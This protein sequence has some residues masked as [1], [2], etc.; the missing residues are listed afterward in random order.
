MLVLEYLKSLNGSTEEILEQFKESHSIKYKYYPEE[1]LVVLNYNQ[2]ESIKDDP[3]VM[4]CRSLVLGISDDGFY[5]VSRAFHRFFN[6]GECPH[7]EEDFDLE[8]AICFEKL[9]GSV[10]RI[11]WYKD[12]WEIGTKGTAFGETENYTGVTFRELVLNAF[13]F[14]DTETLEEKEEH[15]QWTFNMLGSKR[16]TYVME[17]CGKDNRVV[18]PY[19]TNFMALLDVADNETGY[20]YIKDESYAEHVI[21]GIKACGGYTYAP[22]TY[23]FSSEEDMR[24]VVEELP[25]LQ[26]GY[27]CR[28]I[29]SGRRVKVKSPKYLQVHRLRGEQVMSPK[30]IM[31]LVLM[32][33]Q[34]EYLTYFKEDTDKIMPYVEDLKALEEDVNLVFNMFKA[35]KDQKEFALAVKNYDY[36]G[37]LFQAKR[38]GTDPVKEFHNMRD[39]TKLKI[40]SSFRGELI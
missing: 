33:E 21:V 35:L 17:L 6:L 12:R 14:K 1:G 34:E 25:D 11:H 23:S 40:L 18:T 10:I 36:S 13:Q 32:N 31:E 22:K 7:L 26:E 28:D 5:V 15:F 8:D 16:C 2:I 27:V 3:I 39:S 20:S 4:E 38:K 19:E 9:D 30:R 37:C 29:V 24:K